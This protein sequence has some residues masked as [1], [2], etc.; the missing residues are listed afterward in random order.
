MSVSLLFEVEEN[1]PLM[2]NKCN[3]TTFERIGLTRPFYVHVMSDSNSYV[4]KME[5]YVSYCVSKK[6]L[7]PCYTNL[8]R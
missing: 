6:V 8:N 1:M 4:I 7:F 3:V 2:T 5:Q